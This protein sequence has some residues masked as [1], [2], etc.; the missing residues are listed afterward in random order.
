MTAMLRRGGGLLPK[1]I[2]KAQKNVHIFRSY[3]LCRV[4]GGD[5]GTFYVCMWGVRPSYPFEPGFIKK[6]SNFALLNMG[7][8][9]TLVEIFLHLT[10]SL[11]PLYAQ[12]LICILVNMST[13]LKPS[14][15]S[16]HHRGKSM[17][18]KLLEMVQVTIS[19]FFYSMK[20]E[21]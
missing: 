21:K 12:I 13:A 17:Q 4:R 6:E 14:K 18:R 3:T 1:N 5:S 2:R 15:N 20:S 9:Y 10:S 7:S 11:P 19:I 16:I 8:K